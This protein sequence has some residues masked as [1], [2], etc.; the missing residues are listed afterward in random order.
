MD[1]R[2]ITSNKN[3]IAV[4]RQQ[5]S[6]VWLNDIDYNHYISEP[7]PKEGDKN[8]G[9]NIPV[10]GGFAI[11]SDW[12]KILESLGMTVTNMSEL[13]F[14]IPAIRDFHIQM[15]S[16]KKPTSQE[17]IVNNIVKFKNAKT[18]R[19]QILEV[20]NKKSER[21]NAI[22]VSG[23]FGLLTIANNFGLLNPGKA[24]MWF[25]ASNKVNTQITRNLV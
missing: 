9:G 24:D 8:T 5:V 7:E 10:P 23:I 18:K 15:V 25:G 20:A 16:V 17:T 19:N 4:F 12:V 2:E 22:L 21:N 13:G 3:D 11:M 14:D 1:S 6:N